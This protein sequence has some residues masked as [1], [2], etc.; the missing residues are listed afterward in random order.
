MLRIRACAKINLGLEILGRRHDGYHE[1]ITILQEVNLWDELTIGH[2]GDLTMTCNQS[3]L[4]G[5]G[6][7][8]L[9]AAQLLRQMAGRPHGAAIHL[10]KNIPVAAGLGGGSADAAATLV[11]LNMFWEL[12]LDLDQ[13]AVLACQLGADVPFFLRGGTQLAT[14]IGDVCTPLPT[15]DLWVVITVVP[16]KH[17]DKTRR[18]YS[19]LTPDDW[20]D[21][22]GVRYIAEV[23][24]SG[25]AVD[26]LELPSG[27]RRLS[28]ALEP[29]IGG[30][31]D[32]LRRA[33]AAGSLCG[34]GPSVISLHP[35][36]EDAQRVASLV[37]RQGFRVLVART[38]SAAG[39][40]RRAF[41]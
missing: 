18:L 22:L 16:T 8:I 33:G 28:L 35:T 32:A 25:Q 30:A 24:E 7:L 38:V 12:R 31:L 17:S 3:E 36:A 26:D 14:G 21:G 4:I 23:I 6:N 9:R 1:I 19:S 39:E 20:S 34:A 27:F 29:R 41:P 5:D 10:Q 11:G 2:G 15:P 37:E 40:R 13:L